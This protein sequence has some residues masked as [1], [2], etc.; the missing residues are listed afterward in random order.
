MASAIVVLAAIEALSLELFF[1]VSLIGLLVVTE[2]TA[3]LNVTPRWRKRVRVIIVLG[4]LVFA[5]VVARRIVE[6]LGGVI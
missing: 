1:V 2:L 4:L 3:P 6:I 5:Y